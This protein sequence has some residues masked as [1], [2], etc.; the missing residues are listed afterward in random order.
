MGYKLMYSEN[1]ICGKINI[2]RIRSNDYIIPLVGYSDL[3]PVFINYESNTLLT[4]SNIV[5]FII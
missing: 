1:S 5:R 2:L 3:L 4:V